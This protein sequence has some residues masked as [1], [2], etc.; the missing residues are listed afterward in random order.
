MIRVRH[1]V[2]SASDM[3]RNVNFGPSADHK[4]NF[5]PKR[6][7]RIWNF[8]SR[9]LPARRINLSCSRKAQLVYLAIRQCAGNRRRSAREA[10][11][12]KNLSNRL[13]RDAVPGVQDSGPQGRGPSRWV[14]TANLRVLLEKVVAR[15]P[16]RRSGH[17]D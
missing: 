12:V 11:A 9:L 10:E 17:S 1:R 13:K 6:C 15:H 3:G 14:F 5:T 16:F 8:H 2:G 4:R 7:C